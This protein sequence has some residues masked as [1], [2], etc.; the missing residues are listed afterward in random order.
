MLQLGAVVHSASAYEQV[1]GWDGGPLSS[2]ST[3]QVKSET[4]HVLSGVE[5]GQGFLDSC[6]LGLFP[7]PARTVPKLQPDDIDETR[8]AFEEVAGDTISNFLVPI[9]AK[10]LDPG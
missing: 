5:H 2:A 1:G 4:P 8:T 6:Q 3:G 7:L 10:R 9:S